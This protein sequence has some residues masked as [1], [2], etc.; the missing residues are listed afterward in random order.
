MIGWL[1]NSELIV[2]CGHV[3]YFHRALVLVQI[4]GM[5]TYKHTQPGVTEAART[6]HSPS[7]LLRLSSVVKWWGYGPWVLVA[8]L[9]LDL[10][11]RTESGMCGHG[12][13]TSTRTKLSVQVQRWDTAH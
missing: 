5:A 9:Y 7:L 1:G 6:Y 13:T 10:Q 2:V 8:T 12:H 11:Q 3:H 4:V